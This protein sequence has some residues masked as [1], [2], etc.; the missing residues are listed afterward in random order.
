MMWSGKQTNGGEINLKPFPTLKQINDTDPERR[1]SVY[2]FEGAE[3]G[4]HAYGDRNLMCSRV[5]MSA[6]A[7]DDAEAR[8]TG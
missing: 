7:T 4:R 2:V 8:V 5:P 6:F 1:L 3:V